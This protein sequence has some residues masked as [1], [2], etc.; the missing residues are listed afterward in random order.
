[1]NKI[2][3]YSLGLI[4]SKE[5]YSTTSIPGIHYLKLRVP[6]FIQFELTSSCTQKCVFCYNVWKGLST[7]SHNI[8]IKKEIHFEILNHIIKNEIFSVIF[9]G[10]EPLL[11]KWLEKLIEK[12][13]TQNIETSLITNANLLSKQRAKKIKQSGLSSIQ[14]SLHHYV[15]NINNKLVNKNTFNKTIMGI[16]N[17]IEIFSND[18]V[19]V[20]MVVLPNTVNDVYNMA[21]FLSNKGVKYFSVGTPSATGEM[22]KNKNNIITKEQFKNIYYQLISAEKDFKIHTSFTGGFPL[23]ILPNID[24]QSINMI[25]N[26]CDV[27]LNQLVVD[28]IGNLRPCVCLNFNL[29]NILNGALKKIWGKNKVLLNFRKLNYVPQNCKKCSYIHLCRGGCRASALSYYQ[30]FNAIDPLMR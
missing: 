20:N 25:N 28:P 11:V 19:N 23:C 29:G 17:A 13:S 5:V 22:E 18:K 2:K 14:I 7:V 3:N 15:E 6:L 12:A 21:K 26:Y 30:D 1:M 27:G 9:S 24:A 10:G 16:N 8:P 4:N